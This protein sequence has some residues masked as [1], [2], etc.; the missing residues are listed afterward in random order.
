VSVLLWDPATGK[1]LRELTDWPQGP[2][3]I[4]RLSFLTDGST[5]SAVGHNVFS[6]WDACTGKRLQNRTHPGLLDLSPDGKE[7]AAHLDRGGVYIADA[8]TGQMHR[9][10]LKEHITVYPSHIH[11]SP[12]GEFLVG[13]G[14]EHLFAWQ[15]DNG[16]L[17]WKKDTGDHVAAMAWVRSGRV[18]ASITREGRLA[19]WEAETGQ[20]RAY[21]KLDLGEIPRQ[22]ARR[23]E[24]PAPNRALA[25]AVSPAGHC[26]ALAAEDGS[27]SLVDLVRL[28]RPMFANEVRR[29]L[30]TLWGDLDDGTGEEVWRAICT[31]ATCPGETLPYLTEKLR[32]N[33]QP[34]LLRG[35]RLVEALEL[36]HTPEAK[37]LLEK[38]AGAAES[39]LAR[40]AKATLQRWQP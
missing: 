17:L 19:L 15:S 31:I 30:D 37:A 18:L 34:E 6:T 22:G 11:Y 12:G 2:G 10:C 14:L 21:L 25:L 38:L 36:A 24:Q 27:V 16:A 1:L 7:L 28:G 5:L 8:A 3:G 13:K 26:A 39:R 29:Q 4:Y 33:A 32:D 40:Q 35:L 23:S 20:R 9:P